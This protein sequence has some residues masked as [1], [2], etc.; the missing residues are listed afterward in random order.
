MDVKF[1]SDCPEWKT[2]IWFFFQ[3]IIVTCI[4]DNPE[5]FMFFIHVQP[6][7]NILPNSKYW[8][9]DMI[10]FIKLYLKVTRRYKICCKKIHLTVNPFTFYKYF[11]CWLL[12]MIVTNYRNKTLYNKVFSVQ[13]LRVCRC[14][15]AYTEAIQIVLVWYLTQY[16]SLYVVMFQAARYSFIHFKVVLCTIFIEKVGL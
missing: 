12:Y 1:T 5:Y 6:W 16:N 11:I 7:T 3:I 9:K 15:R 13:I 10:F 2:T 4:S 8:S 14:I